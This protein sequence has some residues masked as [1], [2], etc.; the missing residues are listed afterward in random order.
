MG[1]ITR[2]SVRLGHEDLILE[3]GRMAKQ[4]DGSVWVQYGGT[5]VL[6][7]AVGAEQ[8]EEGQDFFPLTCDYREKTYAAGKIPGGYFKREGKPTEKEVLTSRLIDRPIRP[9]FAD[10][11]LNEVQIMATVLSVD[12]ENNPDILAIIGASVALTLSPIPFSEPIAACRVGS[13]DGKF[14]LNPTY[15]QL[16]KSRLDLIMAAS[17]ENIVMIESGSNEVTEEDMIAAIEFGHKAIQAVIELQNKLVAKAGKKKNT[18]SGRDISKEVIEKV[19]KACAGKF[20]AINL[21]NEKEARQEAIDKLYG[22]V[23][24]QFDKEAAGFD[25]IGIKFIYHEVEKREVRNL[26]LKKKK[27]PDGRTFKEIRPI[28][29]EV[30]VLPRT[31]GSALFTR[32]QTQSLCVSTLGT[33]ADEQTIDALEGEFYK[34][35][36]LHYNFPPFSVGEIGPNRGP[37]RREIGHGALAERALKPVMPAQ[38][39]F[40]Y[41]VRIVSDILESNGS[42]SMAT[43]CGG[44]LSLMD[45]GVPIQAPVAGIAMGLV[46]QGADYAV[47]TDIQGVEDHLGDMDFKVAGTRKGIN[48]LQ[49]D[50]K[51]RGLTAQI[52]QQ[53]LADA[54]EARLKI[55]DIME[56][57]I[58]NPRKEISTFAPKIVTLIIPTEKI[59][60]VIGP[61]GK[62]IRKIIE[63]TGVKIDISDD[64]KVLIASSDSK[65][66]EAAIQKVKS[67]TEEAEVG[68]IYYGKVRKI[69]NFGA[70]CEILPGTDGVVHVSEVAEGF[71]KNVEDHLKVGDTIPVKVTGID[72]QSGKISLSHKQAKKE[73]ELADKK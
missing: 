13:I 70:F 41:T 52:M 56:K 24:A 67:I 47:L 8:P 44:A 11:Y 50:I 72:P 69:M 33:S 60:D 29:C 1:E 9:M 55:L 19:E 58:A 34:R 71:V 66:A 62:M 42:S 12:A 15:S 40:P 49:M 27:R 21:I 3:T 35:F 4:S 16:E 45:A 68:R 22:T 57:A 25:E 10:N 54:K 5:V 53:A 2:L 63:E 65:A 20:D 39:Q 59:K 6:V 61:G 64:G 43:V 48:A 7:T 37:G 46:K 32:G 26:I 51:I 30:G 31:H 38:E 28:S 18:A 23:L 36:M 17:K 14:V 73:L